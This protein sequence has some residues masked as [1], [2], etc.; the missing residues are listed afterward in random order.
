MDGQH[1]TLDPMFDA[2]VGPIKHW[3]LAVWDQWFPVEHMPDTV[4]RAKHKL[5][6]ARVSWWSMV[7]GPATAVLA[8]ARRIKWQC[9]SATT[10]KTDVGRTLDLLLDSPV[11]VANEVK[12]AVRRLRW[13]QVE[14]ILLGLIPT[15]P[16]VGKA[17][18]KIDDILV[19]CFTTTTMLV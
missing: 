7:G 5:G 19:P 13:E 11:V 3:A 15:A 18:L 6:S 14:K 10:F 12:A 9:I 17:A 8:S 2:H 1:G 4:E 16:D